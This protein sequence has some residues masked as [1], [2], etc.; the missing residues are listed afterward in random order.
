MWDPAPIASNSKL[1]VI[2]C[3]LRLC[4]LYTHYYR[5]VPLHCVAAS[6]AVLGESLELGG[7]VF[8]LACASSVKFVES[9]DSLGDT[10]FS[11]A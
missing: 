8:S 2:E 7:S 4:T 10:F 5:A 6:A 9:L 3:I 1:P 11:L